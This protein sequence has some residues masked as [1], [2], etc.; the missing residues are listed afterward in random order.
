MTYV[1]CSCKKYLSLCNCSYYSEITNSM[2]WTPLC[3]AFGLADGCLLLAALSDIQVLKAVQ[4]RTY[5]HVRLLFWKSAT[6]LL[7]LAA[8]REV[9]WLVVVRTHHGQVECEPRHEAWVPATAELDRGSR[10]RIDLCD[11]APARGPRPTP[12]SSTR[13]YVR[14]EDQLTCDVLYVR[15]QTPD[16]AHVHVLCC[17]CCCSDCCCWSPCMSS[18][19]PIR[20]RPDP[21]KSNHFV[22]SRFDIVRRPPPH[23][24]NSAPRTPG[25]S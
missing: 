24:R 7:A 5:Q 25:T 20:P 18:S 22:V 8:S 4:T 21:I 12:A 9:P 3:L 1:G 23:L 6:C 15:H 2:C 16:V 11:R 14:L 13:R 10:R 17:D 19:S